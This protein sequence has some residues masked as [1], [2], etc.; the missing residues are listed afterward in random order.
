MLGKEDKEWFKSQSRVRNA[1]VLG[2]STER[3]VAVRLRR[4]DEVLLRFLNRREFDLIPVVVV[5]NGSD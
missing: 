4:K 1:I 2:R 3:R 5:G